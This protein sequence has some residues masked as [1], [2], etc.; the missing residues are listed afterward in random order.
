[1]DD[2]STTNHLQF[3]QEL[4]RHSQMRGVCDIF[5]EVLI[6]NM[7]EYLWEGS[8]YQLQNVKVL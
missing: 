1:M 8:W 7:K 3:T 4:K 6:D 5:G 2:E